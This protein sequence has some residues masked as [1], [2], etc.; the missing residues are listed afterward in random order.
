MGSS[1]FSISSTFA[2]SYREDR[3]PL[4]EHGFNPLRRDGIA[5]L[6]GLHHRVFPVDEL[7][8]GVDFTV[9]VFYKIGIQLCDGRAASARSRFSYRPGLCA[10][11]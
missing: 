7:L 3:E 4:G 11:S 8:I 5:T 6:K 2:W 1:I 10:A 9:F